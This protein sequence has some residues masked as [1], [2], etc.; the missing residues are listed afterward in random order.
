MGRRKGR[1]IPRSHTTDTLLEW[2]VVHVIYCNCLVRFRL[3]FLCMKPF[4]VIFLSS[5]GAAGESAYDEINKYLYTSSE[6]DNLV[7]SDFND[8]FHPKVT[9]F[10]LDM[11]DFPGDVEEL[12]VRATLMLLRICCDPNVLF[13]S[14]QAT[15]L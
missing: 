1:V 15:N 4:G 5:Q 8:P 14:H 13:R 7:I 2:Y 12:T 6:L 3:T 9:G 10:S 11:K